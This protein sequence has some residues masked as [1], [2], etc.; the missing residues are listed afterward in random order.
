MTKNE[1]NPKVDFYFNKARWQKELEQLRM[2]V[3]DCGLTEE[4]KWGVPCYTFPASA[5]RQKSNIVLIHVF[6]EYCAL[7]F[8][9]GALLHD[10]NGILIQQ[11]KNVQAARQV[12]FTNVREIVN[13]DVISGLKAYI[14]EAIEVEKA[15]LKVNLK[16]TT[17]FNMPEEFQNKL[18]AKGGP[19]LKTAFHALTPGRQRAYIL[20]FSAPKQ[21][22]TREARIEKCMQQILNGKGLNDQ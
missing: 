13:P 4:L 19:A 6:K 10:A 22:K 8:F 2:I 15:G 5:G 1:M 20:Y 14:Y 12:R 21:S 18:S 16:K 11:T 9:K 7:L 3:L 17:E